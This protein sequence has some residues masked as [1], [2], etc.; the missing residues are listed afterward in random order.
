MGEWEDRSCKGLKAMQRTT[1]MPSPRTRSA[2]TLPWS[3]LRYFRTRSAG[4]SSSLKKSFPLL[5]LLGE[6]VS[7]VAADTGLFDH[8]GTPSRFVADGELILSEPASAMPW[9]GLGAC[10]SKEAVAHCTFASE[11]TIVSPGAGDLGGRKDSQSNTGGSRRQ[12]PDHQSPTF[13]LLSQQVR[14]E[15]RSD[16]SPAFNLATSGCRPGRL[17]SHQR[18]PRVLVGASRA[19]VNRLEIHSTPSQSIPMGGGR[20][21][22]S[23]ESA[24]SRGMPAFGADESVGQAAARTQ[25]DNWPKRP[26]SSKFDAAEEGTIVP[27]VPGFGSA[28]AHLCPGGNGCSA[29]PVEVRHLLLAVHYLP[30]GESLSTSAPKGGSCPARVGMRKMPRAS[31]SLRRLF[32]AAGV[33]TSSAAGWGRSGAVVTSTWV[34]NATIKL[35]IHNGITR[36]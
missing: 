10:H 4:S 11:R 26:A 17:E 27:C 3:P 33:K 8:C 24:G 23:S 36:L 2:I 1:R 25:R 13:Q 14:Q 31:G 32:L 7:I 19:E 18:K 28:R 16:G 35:H 12:P 34:R 30:V 21:W 29:G 15:M 20:C 6:L 5:A 22:V 9:A